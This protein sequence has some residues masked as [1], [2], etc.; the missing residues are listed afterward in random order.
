MPHH[1]LEEKNLFP[2]MPRQ[3]LLSFW[4]LQND[5]ANWAPKKKKNLLQAPESAIW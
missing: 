3:I 2:S 1:L 4:E 5:L